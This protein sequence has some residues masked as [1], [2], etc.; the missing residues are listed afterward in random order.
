MTKVILVYDLGNSNQA[1]NAVMLSDISFNPELNI[2][3]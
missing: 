1:E 3:T 2:L